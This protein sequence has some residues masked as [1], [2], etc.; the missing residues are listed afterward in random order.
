[1]KTTGTD[2][3]LEREAIVVKFI[4]VNYKNNARYFT[5]IMI[6]SNIESNESYTKYDMADYNV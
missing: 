1:M 6:F 5:S 4:C 3:R 2:L